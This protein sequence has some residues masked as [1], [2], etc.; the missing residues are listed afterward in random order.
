MNMGKTEYV[1][2]TNRLGDEVHF[3]IQVEDLII[4]QVDCLKYLGFK[5]DSSLKYKDH[6]DCL[7][8]KLSSTIF[9]L[10]HMVKF[11]STN[12]LKLI[13]HSL[14]FSHIRYCFRIWCFCDAKD[15]ERVFLIQKKA[16]RVMFK[17]DTKESCR[18]AFTENKLITVPALK[19]AC[20]IMEYFNIKAELL[21][22]KDVHQH[23]TR[24]REEIRIINAKDKNGLIAAEGQKLFNK[25]PK[26]LKL[27]ENKK[28][29]F[30][31][32]VRWLAEK[33]IYSQQEF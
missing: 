19:I 31:V 15:I 29:F 13:Y 32:L 10:R 25:L 2:L 4:S 16:L 12:I 17:L 1:L 27:I 5:L 20:T 9:I 6:I 28:G 14:F 30:K 24:N 11:C 26:E 18:E 33:A 3:S 22:N 7:I 8:K 23:N 21:K